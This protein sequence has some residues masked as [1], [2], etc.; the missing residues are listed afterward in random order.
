MQGVDIDTVIWDQKWLMGSLVAIAII[1][2][3]GIICIL[4]WLFWGRSYYHRLRGRMRTQPIPIHYSNITDTILD[5]EIGNLE[6]E[7][8][9]DEQNSYDKEV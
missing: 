8:R 7:Q 4:V 9:E 6:P 2:V 3:G 1:L 5:I